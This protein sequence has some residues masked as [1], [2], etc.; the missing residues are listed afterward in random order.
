MKVISFENKNHLSNI[1]LL[2]IPVLAASTLGQTFLST[3]G[4]GSGFYGIIQLVRS[5]IM[6]TLYQGEGGA[7]RLPG[8]SF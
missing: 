7:Q 1:L 6:F 2:N 8:R 4:R 3:F 5:L